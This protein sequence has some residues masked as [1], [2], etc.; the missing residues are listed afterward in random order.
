MKKKYLQ[1]V[2]ELSPITDVLLGSAG[3]YGEDNVSGTP[4]ENI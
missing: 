4:W 3:N 2:C 1:P